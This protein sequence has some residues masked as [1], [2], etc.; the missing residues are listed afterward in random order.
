MK[1]SFQK[2]LTVACA[3]LITSAAAVTLAHADTPALTIAGTE[4]DLGG[5]GLTGFE[6]TVNQDIN[7][8]QLGFNA[9]SLGGGDAPHVTLWNATAGLG[10]LTQIYDTGDILGQVTSNPAGGQN[11]A[12]SY[13]SVGTSIELVTGQTYLISAPAYWVPTYA[14]TSITTDPVLASA[15]FLQTGNGT[16]NG[17]ANAGYNFANL[18]A[19][20]NTQFPATVSFQ[21]TDATVPEPSTYVMLGA[22]LAV[23]VIVLR[24]RALRGL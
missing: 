11:A 17:W 13:V 7:L 12:L 19:A 2:I 21:Y 24:R 23:L 22:G 20:P 18:V 3:A 8:T 9:L 14:S 10:S 16:W 4:T 6:F 5:Y 15:S 1:T